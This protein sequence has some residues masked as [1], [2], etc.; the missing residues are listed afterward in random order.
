[1]TRGNELEPLARKYYQFESGH[2]VVET[3]LI[4]TDAQ[5]CGASLDG[6]VGDDGTIEIKCLKRINHTR[7]VLADEVPEDYL[8][9]IQ[10]GLKITGRA[11]CDFVAFHPEAPVDG[12]IIRVERDENMIG[13]LSLALSRFH[14]QVNRYIRILTERAA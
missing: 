4:M 9:Q 10:G 11:W 12:Y 8:P 5:D 7:I 2:K 13:A 3:G 1:M 6:L 14:D